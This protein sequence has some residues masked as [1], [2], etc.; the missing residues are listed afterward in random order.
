[1]KLWINFSLHRFPSTLT[2]SFQK[3]GEKSEDGK[4]LKGGHYYYRGMEERRADE[5]SV[6]E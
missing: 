1:M 2:S 4:T 3:K 5:R 6:D